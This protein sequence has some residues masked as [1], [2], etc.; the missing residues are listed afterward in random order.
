MVEDSG[1]KTTIG[2]IYVVIILVVFAFELFIV[3]AKTVVGI[4]FKIRGMMIKRQRANLKQK[5]V[6][7]IA[8]KVVATC[9]TDH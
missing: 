7:P 3:L 8:E 5:Q 6:V 1:S 2:W 9:A 4:W